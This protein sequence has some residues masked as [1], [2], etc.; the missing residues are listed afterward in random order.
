MSDSSYFQHHHKLL[1]ALYE[2]CQQQLPFS[3]ERASDVDREFLETLKTISEA[4][5]P[6][7]A[8]QQQSK[9]IAPVFSSEDA[10]EGATAFAEKRAPNW[11]GK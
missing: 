10:I 4:N 5:G 2:Y 8:F 6:D 9:Y 1:Q 3:D 11:K 7:E